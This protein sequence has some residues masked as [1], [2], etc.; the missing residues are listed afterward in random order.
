MARQPI[1]WVRLFPELALFDSPEERRKAI[2]EACN[3]GPKLIF[4]YMVVAAIGTGCLVM[5][6]DVFYDQFLNTRL[7]LPDRL[8]AVLCGGLPAVMAIALARRML[9]TPIRQRLREQ[10]NAAGKPVCMAC[11]YDLRAVSEPRCPEC[12]L[13]FDPCLITEPPTAA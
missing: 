8:K 3:L 13:K 12:G 2:R 7:P 4:R 5:A 1:R 6:A 11:G 9:R 10:L